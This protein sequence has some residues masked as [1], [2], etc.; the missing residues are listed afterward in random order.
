MEGQAMLNTEP[1]VELSLS[2]NHRLLFHRLPRQG[3]I[4]VEL[5][6]PTNQ[7]DGHG[8]GWVAG[9]TLEGPDL[10]KF[11]EEIGTLHLQEA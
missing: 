2:N 5:Q 8:Y 11:C 3:T 4:Y 7:K 6:R 9:A 1:I 10:Q